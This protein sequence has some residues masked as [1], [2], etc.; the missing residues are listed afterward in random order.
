MITDN[1][2]ITGVRPTSWET[3]AEAVSAMSR[4]HSDMR[5][6]E[7]RLVGLQD[8]Q[9]RCFTENRPADGTEIGRQ[10][11]SLFVPRADAQER[12]NAASNALQLVVPISARSINAKR[13]TLR[14]A[15]NLLL[16]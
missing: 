10:V 1:S 2:T 11:E 4:A 16:I 8:E 7:A 15:I 13:R 3:L 6:L 9:R 12:L 14:N 5:N